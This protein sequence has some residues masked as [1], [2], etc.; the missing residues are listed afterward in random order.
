MAAISTASPL[1][2]QAFL[3]YLRTGTPI[4][5]SLKAAA[6]HPTPYYIWRT[7]GDDKV[8]PEHAANAGMIFAW[9]NPP[10]TG[11]PGEA[12]NCRCWAEDYYWIPNTGTVEPPLDPAYPELLFFPL[13]RFVSILRF[14]LR[15][16][17]D[18][19]KITLTEEQAKNLARFDAKLPKNAGP[20]EV[21]IGKN[22]ERI[23][24]A[25]VPANNIPGSYARYEKTVDSAGN[26]ISYTKTTYAPDG[27]VVHTK[28]KY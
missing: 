5:L 17:L 15:P 27:S 22:G 3:H 28:T 9:D 4:A 26:T 7:Q 1:Y 6:E 12:V 23:F 20:I 21:R 8:R 19:Q 10:S 16:I 18:R 14:I 2:R 11:H 25:D 24:S 13:S